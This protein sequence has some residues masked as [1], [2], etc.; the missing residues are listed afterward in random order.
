MLLTSDVI[1]RTV[2]ATVDDEVLEVSPVLEPYVY[3]PTALSLQYSVLTNIG[4]RKAKRDH[5]A[6]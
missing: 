2:S 1:P 6:T 3:R 4:V 5:D